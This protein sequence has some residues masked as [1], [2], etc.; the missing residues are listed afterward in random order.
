MGP[1]PNTASRRDGR[2]DRAER[3][4]AEAADG[5]VPHHLPGSASSSVGR[6]PPVGGRGAAAPPPAARCRLG[7]ARTDRRTRRGRRRRSAE[8][9]GTRSTVSSRTITTP[10]PSVRPR[11]AVPSKVERQV[12]LVRAT[13]PPGRAPE[14][15][16]LAARAPA[17]TPP[18]RRQQLASV[19]RTAPRTRRA[20]RPGRTRRTA[21]GR[22]SPRCRSRRGRAPIEHDGQH[23]DERLDVVDQRSACRTARPRPG[24]A[25]CCAARRGSP[26][27]S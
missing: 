18:A 8:Q 4:L 14:Q 12:E 19:S 15:H 27:S 23:V 6:A 16:R 10:E 11:R 21:S 17:A 1:S 20:A 26:R 5:G 9:V 2:L 25:A 7:T 24:T 22:S 3:R 13:K